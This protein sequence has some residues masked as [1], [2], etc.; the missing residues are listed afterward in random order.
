ME[1]VK[2]ALGHLDSYHDALRRGWSPD[3]IS[4]AATARRELDRIVADPQGFIDSL[5]DREARGGP[6]TMPDGTQFPRLPGYRRWMWDGEFCGSVGFR[7]QPG[8]SELPPHVLGHIGY[9]VVPWKRNR[10]YARA[11]LA[12]MLPAAAAEGLDHIILTTEPDNLAS[13]RVLEACGAILVERF[14][15]PEAY[16]GGE[17]LKYRIDLR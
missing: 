15:K 16:G 3:N 2:P 5:E 4:P 12:A 9:G 14:T 8:T 17:S 11:A 1:L 7:W 13:R 10:G 6:I